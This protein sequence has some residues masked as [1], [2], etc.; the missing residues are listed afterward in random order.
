MFIDDIK[1]Y[2]DS[3][4]A[5]LMDKT[6]LKNMDDDTVEI[7]TPHLD[8]HN[9]YLQFY[10][11]KMP[12]GLLFSDGGY[13]LDDLATSGVL[14]NTPK[15]TALLQQIL[16]GFGVKIQDDCLVTMA[17]AQNFPVR[18]NSFIQA[19]LAV[20]DMFAMSNSNVANF[21]FED[22]EYWLDEIGARYTQNV[23]LTGQSG[24]NF[25]FDFLIP[26]SKQEPERLL[27]TIN[28]PTKS[29]IEHILFGWSD[30]KETRRA[31]TLLYVVLNDTDHAI[32][33]S[34]I[35]SLV[36]YNINPIKWSDR[37]QAIPQLVN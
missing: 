16:N 22:V 7:T 34:S 4:I 12:D 15:R 28:N 13:I 37:Q 25:N 5:W 21:F 17:N 31:D 18:K 24:F 36:N 9:D 11:Q 3:Y 23:N 10:I 29:N 30:T 14:F 27:H 8:R 26:H 1:Q 19:M 32:S 20:N 33:G 2:H 35:Q 6:C